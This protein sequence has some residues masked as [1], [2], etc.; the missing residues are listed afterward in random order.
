LVT[1]SCTFSKA[2]CLGRDF[3]GDPRMKNMQTSKRK[4]SKLRL[5]S[6]A[7][8]TPVLSK[9]TWSIVEGYLSNKSLITQLVEAFLRAAW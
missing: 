5:K 9:I 1:L 7:A 2:H 3:L 6:S 8:G 4:R